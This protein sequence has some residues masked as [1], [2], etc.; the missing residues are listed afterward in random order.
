M[1]AGDLREWRGYDLEKR[2]RKF[3]RAFN[4][5][6]IITAEEIPVIAA[7]P[8]YFLFGSADK[9]VDYFDDPSRMVAYQEES[10]ALH[11]REV[12]D[13]YI[14]YFM[15]WF[16]TGIMAAAFGCRYRIGSN[17]GQDPGIVSTC[18][19]D[20]R[21]I[22][23][24]KA[25]DPAS[26]PFT[27]KVLDCI[28]YAVKESD[29]PVGLTDMNSPLSTLGQM[30]GAVNLYTWMYEEPHA[31]HDLME[32]VTD[33]LI[34]WVKVQKEHI[35]E[36]LGSSNGLQGVWTPRGGVWLSDDDLILI[37]PELYEKFVVPCYSR[38]F[39]TFG[40]GHL[41]FCG[42]GAHQAKNIKAIKGLT[43]VNNSPMYDLESFTTL[44]SEIGDSLAIELQD[45][46]PIDPAYYEKVFG[47][48]DSL[49]GLIV[50]TFVEDTLGMSE[51]G[52]SVPV[53]WD[54]F[55]QANRIVRA[56]REAAQAFLG[57]RTLPSSRGGAA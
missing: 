56:I 36:P 45:A 12:D 24:L 20:V 27:R 8:T 21:D 48:M 49:K 22:A 10:C 16:G 3:R 52:A 53:T 4:R 19:D 15:P 32:I 31:V 2:K 9:P 30:C 25:P 51:E 35:G 28:D 5:E 54:R 57:G 11:L 43:A 38:I 26:N 23:R 13:D 40:G 55:K 29:L 18:I 34:S 46:A 1:A 39:T 41:H 44:Y 33:A 42:N 17:G 47:C 37:G 6:E 7:T 50:A 14:P